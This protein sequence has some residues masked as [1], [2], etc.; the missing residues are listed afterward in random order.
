MADRS[1]NW[2]VIDQIE[3]LIAETGMSRAELITRSGMRRNTFF[4]KMRGET[5][6]N[7]DDIAKLAEAL[8]VTPEMIFIRAADSNVPAS[9]DDY[10]LAAK[11]RSRDRGGEDGQG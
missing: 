10:G 9:Q 3:Q 11:K 4:V 7:T 6:L 5:A 1:F 8:G 2:R